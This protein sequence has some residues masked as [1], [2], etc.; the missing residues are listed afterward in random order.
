MNK[1]DDNS[2]VWP[3]GSEEDRNL[4]KLQCQ[5]H[6]LKIDYLGFKLRWAKEANSP[7]IF[8][9]NSVK[10]NNAGGQTQILKWPKNH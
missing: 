4:E 7:M 2:L 8:T 1:L 9:D 6:A 5:E 10:H 3:S